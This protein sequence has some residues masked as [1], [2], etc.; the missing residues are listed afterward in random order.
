MKM[1]TNKI[2]R[3]WKDEEFR[4]ILPESEQAALPAQSSCRTRHSV[5]IVFYLSGTSIVMQ[6]DKG[7]GGM[8][9]LT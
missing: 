1:S 4:A 6:L 5:W 7:L 8:P 2:A 9:C 3:A